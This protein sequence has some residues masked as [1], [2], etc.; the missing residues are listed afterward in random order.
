MVRHENVS[1]QTAF[2]PWS[3][4]FELTQ[5]E[6][7]ILLTEKTACAIV[8]SLNDVQRYFRKPESCAA[9]HVL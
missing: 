1:V 2:E 9:R 6:P 5:I 7:V 8:S 3:E 4:F